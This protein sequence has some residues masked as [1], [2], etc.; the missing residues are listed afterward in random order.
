MNVLMFTEH[1]FVSLRAMLGAEIIKL[2]ESRVLDRSC[3]KHLR[4]ATTWQ[5]RAH[6]YAALIK[7]I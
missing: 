1:H 4:L 2:Q 3:K 5:G 7:N 6:Q